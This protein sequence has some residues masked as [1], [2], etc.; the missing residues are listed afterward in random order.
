MFTLPISQ[1]Y[2]PE[3]RQRRDFDPLLITELA[4]SIQAHGLLQPIVVRFPREGEPKDSHVLVAGERRLRA[5]Q[6]IY[7]LGGRFG[8]GT[9]NPFPDQHVPA[10][11]IGMLD[12]LAAE[13]AELEENLRRKDLSWQEQAEA[14]QR[15]YALRQKQ[16][17]GAGKKIGQADIATEAFPNLSPATAANE[18]AANLALAKAIA[19][20]PEVAKAKD[21]KAAMKLVKQIEATNLNK[22]L[23]AAVG[24][25]FSSAS[26]TLIN[27]DCFEYMTTLP[28]A[29]FDVILTDP[30]YG[31]GAD[32]FGDGAGRL[33]NAE[34]HY[35]D[36]YDAWFTMMGDLADESFRLAKPEAHAYVFCDF[37]RFHELKKL[38]ERAGWYVFRTPLLAYK[39]GSGRVPLPEHGPRR[40]YETIL[41]AIKGNKKVTGIYSDVI[42]CTLEENLGHGA[43]KPVELFADLLKRSCRPGDTVFDPFAGTGTIFPAAHGL[44]VKAIGC[45]LAPE[46]YGIAVQRLGKLDEQP[47]MI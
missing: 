20:N 26:H 47:K 5:M 16:A 19:V 11:D 35:D 39:L 18:V 40:Q 2:V 33:T 36:S 24:R 43:N 38:M 45:E 42:P 12:E 8:H 23:A 4:N 3:N 29:S 7:E 9:M 10:T 28:D 30:P 1:I 32:R 46:Y 41:Y 34:H 21:P 27:G 44:R 25:D 13:E 37:D 6:Q 31:M 22:Q 14:V 17:E 15:L